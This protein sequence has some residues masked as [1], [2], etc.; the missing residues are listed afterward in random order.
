MRPPPTPVLNSSETVRDAALQIQQS[1]SDLFL[2]R[3]SPT[4]W[5][6]IDRNLLQRFISEGKAEMTL[7]SLLPPR[8]LPY[9]HPDYPLEMA[10]RYVYQTPLV[11]VVSRADLRQLEGVISSEGVLAKYRAAAE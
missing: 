6:S 9:L 3:L 8:Q 2:V 7:G 1:S 10:L 11:P 5:T 4:G